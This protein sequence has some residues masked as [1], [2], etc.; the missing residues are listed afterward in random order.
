MLRINAKIHHQEFI[1]ICEDIQ[2]LYRRHTISIIPKLA[3]E[4]KP[5][6]GTY[7]QR[8]RDKQLLTDSLRA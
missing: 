3:M 5:W 1:Q 2:A 4:S 8:T 7:T 6:Y